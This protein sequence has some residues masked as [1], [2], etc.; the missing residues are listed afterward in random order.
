LPPVR[1]WPARDDERE[2]ARLLR[3]PEPALKAEFLPLEKGLAVLRLG[4]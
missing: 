4:Q 2:M 1:G 3:D